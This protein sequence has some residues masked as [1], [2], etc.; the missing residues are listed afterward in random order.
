MAGKPFQPFRSK[1]GAGPWST[2]KLQG[3]DKEAA[4]HTHT[5]THTHTEYRVGREHLAACCREAL[6]LR[7]VQLLGK[8]LA[9]NTLP[10]TL[11]LRHLALDHSDPRSQDGPRKAG[12]P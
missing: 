5:H 6:L 1:A 8:D 10:L 4:T 11:P 3:Q 2:I 7:R 12:G 9:H